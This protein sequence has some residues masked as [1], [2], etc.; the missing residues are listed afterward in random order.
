[1]LSATFVGTSSE[2]PVSVV[3]RPKKKFNENS[4]SWNCW[5][6]RLFDNVGGR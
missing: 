6:I 2:G 3:C 1:M 5:N 4:L